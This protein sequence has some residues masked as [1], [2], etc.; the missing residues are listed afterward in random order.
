MKR[1]A[2]SP[3]A[4]TQI[5]MAAV[6]GAALWMAYWP[7]RWG[8]VRDEVRQTGVKRIDGDDL[9]KWMVTRTVSPPVLLDVRSV[10][11][12]EFSHLPGARRVN[13]A[14][15]LGENLLEGQLKAQ[16]VVYDTVGFDAAAFALR[17][18]RL[19]FMDVQVL[20]GGIFQWANENRPLSGPKG[21]AYKVHP[22]TSPY[23]PLLDRG[24]RAP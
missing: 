19:N 2:L 24:R 1:R 16:I 4:L 8:Q 17:L 12:F 10:A 22:G 18:R 13:A 20:E 15:S 7:W 23:L 21:P 6:I 5:L 14:A 9:Q 3:F 11:E